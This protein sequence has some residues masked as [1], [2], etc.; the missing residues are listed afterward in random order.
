MVESMSGGE[1]SASGVPE[2]RRRFSGG[3]ALK[4][5]RQVAGGPVVQIFRGSDG[6]ALT[7]RAAWFKAPGLLVVVCGPF[8]S[9]ADVDL[10]LAYGLH[11]SSEHAELVLVIPAGEEAGRATR[12][13]Q[14]W[15]AKPLDVWTYDVE[16][17]SSGGT[18]SARF[19]RPRTRAEV[20]SKYGTS[21]GWGY[22]VEAAF[23]PDDHIDTLGTKYAWIERLVAWLE[24]DEDIAP[25]HTK[26]YLAWSCAGKI[27][28]KITVAAAHLSISAGIQHSEESRKP[29]VIRI[30]TDLDPVQL[31][32]IIAKMA[33]AAALLLG[34]NDGLYP[35]HRLQASIMKMDPPLLDLAS[36]LR[37]EFP[38]WRPYPKPRGRAFVDFV[39]VDCEGSIHLVETKVGGDVMLVLQGLDYWIWAMANRGELSRMFGATTRKPQISIDFVVS[40]KGRGGCL[41]PYT[42]AQSAALDPV[43]GKRFWEITG[44]QDGSRPLLTPKNP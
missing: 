38:A 3:P 6:R 34:G 27:V 10:A 18:P 44:W 20:L 35:E 41:S 16:A 37:P 24:A 25:T 29:L 36:P 26:N 33:A 2:Q 1:E 22:G 40:K 28:L 12:A 43:V 11:H 15:I 17:L 7:T 4:L 9:A 42:A 31:H 13:R 23:R 8:E 30:G 14:P 39:G 5:A 19:R 32:R 21:T